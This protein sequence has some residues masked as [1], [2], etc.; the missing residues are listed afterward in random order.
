[1]TAVRSKR[2]TTEIARTRAL[3]AAN[4]P[5]EPTAPAYV[6]DP[7]LWW[8]VALALAAALVASATLG[9]HLAVRGATFS[10]VTLVAAWYALRTGTLRGIAFGLFAG[11]CEDAVAGTTGV[12]WMVATAF[13]AAFAGRLTRTW[14][15]DTKLVLVP[16]AAFVTLVRVGAFLVAM[17][18]Q[19]RPLPATLA[20]LHVALWQSAL[21]ALV[22]FVVLSAA[23][24]VLGAHA[25]RR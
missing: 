24:Q 5:S 16:F 14:L 7:P 18:A 11:A 6:P 12:A 4:K 19:G 2:S 22:A 23:P 17:Q 15:A 3:W 25:H 20:T 9:P 10:F 21:D 1:M 8:H 13:A